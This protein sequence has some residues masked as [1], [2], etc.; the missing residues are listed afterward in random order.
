MITILPLDIIGR[1]RMGTAL[2]AALSAA[3][4]PVRG[5]MPRGADANGA[6]IVLLCVPDREIA[7]ASALLSPGAIV[8]HVSASAD[9]AL[10]APHERFVMHPLLSVTGADADF[11]SATAA[12][13]GSTVRALAVARAL[14][15]TLGMR[16]REVPAELRALYHAAASAASN[17]LV[18][19]E[20]MAEALAAPVGLDR[21]AFVPLVR[22]TVD[23]WA[24]HGA[25]ES[26]TGPIVRGDLDTERRQ[27]AAVAHH[28]PALVPL[29]DALAAATHA[30]AAQPASRSVPTSDASDALSPGVHATT[31][32]LP[33]GDWP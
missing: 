30:L 7:T 20:A 12:I 32:A 6:A 14:A 31:A 4:V 18:T 26:L 19:L 3:G 25:R 22:A 16:P 23:S 21:S 9:L 28:M 1:G 2:A 24:K 8:G 11:A 10:L 5:P 15:T 29:W 17:Y 33:R 27:R 13:D